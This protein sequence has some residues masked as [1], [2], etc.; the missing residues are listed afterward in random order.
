MTSGA[1]GVLR[2][3][4][5]PVP[6]ELTVERR[7]AL[8]LLAEAPNGMTDQASRAHGFSPALIVGLVG[9]GYAEAKPRTMRAAGKTFAFM[10][11]VI[12]S[13]GRCAIG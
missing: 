1:S 4:V 5:F 11:F 10:R 8:Q 9:A 13:A 2:E 7:R 3:V 12:T 6:P